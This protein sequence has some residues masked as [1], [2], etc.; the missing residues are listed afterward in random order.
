MFVYRKKPKQKPPSL[1]NI[2]KISRKQS[3]NSRL[4]TGWPHKNRNFITFSATSKF[5]N[6]WKTLT[7]N[8]NPYFFGPLSRNNISRNMLAQR[9]SSISSSIDI[10]SNDINLINGV[11]IDY[12]KEGKVN[13]R[14]W[15]V[16][17]M[18]EACSNLTHLLLLCRI[19]DLRNLKLI[20]YHTKNND[21]K[22]LLIPFGNKIHARL[23]G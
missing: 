2:S 17:R 15:A 7:K 6:K 18:W 9:Q 14:D 4:P 16:F 10:N 13:E 11:A 23:F 3:R 8:A 19:I 12:V 21:K 1:K 20:Y 22:T 5:K